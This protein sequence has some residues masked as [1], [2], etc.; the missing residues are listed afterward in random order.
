MIFL[1]RKTKNRKEG[2]SIVQFLKYAFTFIL[3]LAG[4]WQKGLYAQAKLVP[5]KHFDHN[6]GLLCKKLYT[7]CSD[8]H[9][10]IWLG[11]DN[12]VFRFDGKNFYHYTTRDGLCDSEILAMFA[13]SKGRVWCAGFNGKISVIENGVVDTWSPFVKQWPKNELIRDLAEDDL[14]NV[15][16][17]SENAELMRVDTTGNLSVWQLQGLRNSPR[18]LMFHNGRLWLGDDSRCYLY[19][20]N[21]LLD[22]LYFPLT[23]LSY[24]EPE[25]L[26]ICR[27]YDA[28]W[29]FHLQTGQ[30]TEWF[31]GL[32][33]QFP[34]NIKNGIRFVSQLDA[35][36]LLI[37]V[38]GE[39]AFMYDMVSHTLYRI[40]LP[41]NTLVPEVAWDTQ[42]N[43]WMI[44]PDHGLYGIPLG[45]DSLTAR[46]MPGFDANIVSATEFDNKLIA[47][48]DQGQWIEYQS[49]KVRT[50][51]L[52][53]QK[54]L[55][56]YVCFVEAKDSL[57]VVGNNYRF[58][59]KTKRERLPNL[60]NK[61]FLVYK[62][63]IWVIR[64][65]D[66]LLLENHPSDILYKG[67]TYDMCIQNDALWFSGVSGLC[68]YSFL[69]DSLYLSVF[70]VP[71][72]GR[73]ECVLPLGDSLQLIASSNHGL[74]LLLN[75]KKILGNL[76]LENGL[77]DNDCKELDVYPGG[78][79]VRHPLGLSKISRN[80]LGVQTI[81][82][83]GGIPM[84]SVNQVLMSGNDILLITGKGLFR[85]NVEILF[86]ELPER[87]TVQFVRVHSKGKPMNPKD[88]VLEPSG[89]HLRID[90]AIPEYVH[91][92]RVQYRWRINDEP[93]TK[94]SNT[95]LELADLSPG[96]YRFQVAATAPGLSETPVS[97][98]EFRVRK[99]IWENVFFLPAVVVL[100]LL[101]LWLL[102]WRRFRTKLRKEREQATIRH[103][104]LSYEQRALNAMMNPHFVFN[105]MGSIQYLLLDGHIAEANNY[106]IKFSRLVRKTLEYTQLESCTLDDELERLVLYL[107][108]EKLRLEEN[109][110]FEV[111]VEDGLDP[112]SI[113]IPSMIFQTYVENAVIHGAS[114]GKVKLR[115]AFFSQENHLHV[116]I[117]DDGPGF[118]Y[119][120]PVRRSERFGLS[121]TE[122]RLELLS[123]ITGKVYRVQVMSPLT[124][125]GGTRVCLV[126]P[127][128]TTQIPPGS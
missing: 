64:N 101:L 127:M 78:W 53:G 15:Y 70:N 29:K 25:R 54:K 91:P 13:D 116:N 34:A 42:H 62:D 120:N 99:P 1:Q 108:M 11:G 36:R 37:G 124:A 73:I 81:S 47:V 30:F 71:D 69:T 56:E 60:S 117:E 17:V 96:T 79:V 76:S 66:A 26:V 20:I 85:E 82:E 115:L 72:G 58:V 118:D 9:G 95:S 75:G 23:A 8:V 46:A 40:D 61:N 31:T 107:Q 19:Q 33:I 90:Y 55:V 119:Q 27:E 41:P 59:Y 125:T 43:L 123:K 68:R 74:Y 51:W 4:A 77:Q 111:D 83:W 16:L 2:M 86:R 65:H 18:R 94:T 49:G 22:G 45:N 6:N 44:T 14:G 89:N 100:L 10:F 88:L 114:R 32:S 80:G 103:R 104:L 50:E 113:H 67:R 93:W 92:E 48:T 7:I 38:V 28:A 21:P 52:F 39:G 63:S 84:S 112:E 87:R 121:A 57:Y 98:L 126:F 3:L 5:T 128:D 122:K 12:G 106:L 24:L 105:A 35:N 110:S 102:W 97:T 109:L